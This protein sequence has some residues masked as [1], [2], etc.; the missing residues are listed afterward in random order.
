MAPSR[1]LVFITVCLKCGMY[2]DSSLA[3]RMART[4][5]RESIEQ[6]SPS[7]GSTAAGGDRGAFPS[8]R[9]PG[10]HVFPRPQ[11]RFYGFT[12]PPAHQYTSPLPRFYQKWR[13]RRPPPPS[14]PSEPFEPSEPSEPSNPKCPS[15]LRTFSSPMTREALINSQNRISYVFLSN[16]TS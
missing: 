14:E 9:R 7:G 15:I 4:A 13:Q 1:R 11:G 3:L 2:R 8:G 16:A 5:G 12:S 6:T 10:W